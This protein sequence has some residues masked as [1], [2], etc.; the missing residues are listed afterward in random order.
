MNG[1]NHAERLWALVN[2]EMWLRRFIDGQDSP[3][4]ELEFAEVAVAK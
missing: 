1:E 3:E 2:F 4:H